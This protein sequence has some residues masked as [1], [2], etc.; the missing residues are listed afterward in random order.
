M[1]TILFYCLER[2]QL[3]YISWLPIIMINIVPLHLRVLMWIC[4]LFGLES[5]L[6]SINSIKVKVL[7]YKHHSEG[8]LH[9][10]HVMI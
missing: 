9:Y 6:I 5:C 2:E 1:I 7:C 3:N 8:E 4:N 10:K